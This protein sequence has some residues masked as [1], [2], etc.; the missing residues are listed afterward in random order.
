ML[1]LNDDVLLQI[2][3]EL[4]NDKKSLYSCLLVNRAWCTIAVQILWK[5]PV[6]HNLTDNAL[7]IL[8]DVIL[9]HLSEESRDILKNQGINNFVAGDQRP[10]FN[11]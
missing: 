2:F 3:D 6:Q 9:L 7:N 8:L 11:C 10:L 5:N 1:Y 4:E